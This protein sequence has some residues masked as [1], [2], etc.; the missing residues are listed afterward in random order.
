M[1][2]YYIQCSPIMLNLKLAVNFKNSYSWYFF[3]LTNL[4]LIVV[5]VKY[6]ASKVAQG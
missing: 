4:K 1:T 3:N 2:P 5:L 6:R